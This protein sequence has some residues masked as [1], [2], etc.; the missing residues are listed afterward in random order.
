M[1]IDFEKYGDSLVPAIVQDDKTNVVL[2]L[3]FMNRE[4]FERTEK[5]GRV[6]FFSRSRQKLWTKGETSGN[7]L[8]AKEIL[9][10]CDADTILIKAVPAVAVCHTGADT[11]FGEI[12]E[13]DNFIFELEKTIRQRKMNPS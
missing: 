2:M 10:D 4:A 6:T 8:D 13:S 12:N 5:S 7:Y 9:M 3:G 1:E 11:C